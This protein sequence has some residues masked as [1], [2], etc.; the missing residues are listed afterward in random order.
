ML[1]HALVKKIISGFIV[2]ALAGSTATAISA[3]DWEKLKKQQAKEIVKLR[4]K[5]QKDTRAM[6]VLADYYF[7][8]FG[9]KR[10]KAQAFTL[11]KKASAAGDAMAVYHM[12]L[13]HETGLDIDN[14]GIL[15][16]PRDRAKGAALKAK[17]I[18]G[19][20][21]L[22]KKGDG[23]AL[24]HMAVFHRDG[25]HGFKKDR[26]KSEK[27]IKKG[28]GQKYPRS[29]F[30]HGKNVFDY[31]KKPDSEACDIF[32]NAAAIGSAEGAYQL[33]TCYRLGAGRSKNL[34][35]AK[36]WYEFAVTKGLSRAMTTLG[37][38]YSEADDD[39][40]KDKASELYR[41]ATFEGDPGG[42][43]S[44]AQ[45]TGF[46]KQSFFWQQAL[47]LDPTSKSYLEIVQKK[48]SKDSNGRD[49]II[50]IAPGVYTSGEL[51]KLAQQA[52]QAG[53]GYAELAKDFMLM[54]YI[55]SVAPV[56]LLSLQ[57]GFLEYGRLLKFSDDNTT[58]FM[59]HEFVLENFN[60]QT[61]ISSWDVQTKKL[62][63]IRALEPDQE[64]S[65][66]S[67]DG[68]TIAIIDKIK[69]DWTDS[70]GGEDG[71]KLKLIDTETGTVKSML[72]QARG[73]NK[74][75]LTFFTGADKY[76]SVVSSKYS[77]DNLRNESF[78]LELATGNILYRDAGSS[79][80]RRKI[81]DDGKHVITQDIMEFDAKTSYQRAPS[82]SVSGGVEGL[83]F[84]K[85]IFS[86]DQ[87]YWVMPRALFDLKEKTLLGDHDAAH[88]GA[89]FVNVSGKPLLV[90][91]YSDAV[92]T[93]L[94]QGA[95]IQKI[96]SVP[97]DIKR[98]ISRS[99]IFSPDY[100]LIATN[101]VRADSTLKETFIQNYSIPD[102]QLIAKQ[103]EK[104]KVSANAKQ[105]MKDVLAMFEAGFGDMAL[106]KFTEVVKAKPTNIDPVIRLIKHRADIDATSLGSALKVAIE[107]AEADKGTVVVG[108]FFEKYEGKP[109]TGLAIIEDFVLFDSPLKK[110]GAKIGDRIVSLDGRPYFAKN[111][112]ELKEY[113][114]NLP[115]GQ[116]L[117]LV[118]E[119]GGNQFTVK[120][121][122][123]EIQSVSG[124]LTTS[125]TLFHYGLIGNAAGHPEI[126]ELAASKIEDILNAGIYTRYDHGLGDSARQTIA[127]LRAVAAANR[128]DMKAAF[129]FLIKEKSMKAKK[130]WGVKHF[131]W[132][133]DLFADLHKDPKKLAYI[134]GVK[135]D[136][137]PK[138]P[139][140]RI[141]PAPYWTLDGRL[142]EP[143]VSAML[144]EEGGAIID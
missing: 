120:Y 33:G 85:S 130:R 24:Y 115:A 95:S 9:L 41:M 15:E 74:F 117:E 44:L 78:L 122:V 12:G 59:A 103:L 67:S 121:P 14:D 8:G 39:A 127:M 77:G 76:L 46:S 104:L 126:A 84:K 69:K 62:I 5:A 72:L 22:A 109:G 73:E 16:I 37:N 48:R 30:L 52:A 47:L 140:A 13:F 113:R 43:H 66:I 119:R 106:E 112:S 21:N 107:L 87:R 17:A 86:P 45:N 116:V 143:G 29:I 136:E 4:K 65:S 63:Q 70:F 108:A 89:G 75:W 132:Y 54:G 11:Y 1:R 38:M 142:I 90:R 28:V 93:Y 68:K 2:I 31:E 92:N 124:L 34:T 138:L 133:P 96:A 134:L 139:E 23:E 27:F 83:V 81:S 26:K 56:K 128:G 10:N 98:D 53:A 64:I 19:V 25:L 7:W 57:N 105:E 101:G 97:Y 99:N 60:K 88:T 82:C 80:L 35:S 114:N 141:K 6:A 18:K 91:F 94:M 111:T 79:A 40:S 118:L 125:E 32:R 131:S 50:G 137:L 135:V 55:K 20:E 144:K 123:V 110:A 3:A 58:L 100:S 51:A 42:F 61:V 129:G 102:E 36:R 71:P 49:E